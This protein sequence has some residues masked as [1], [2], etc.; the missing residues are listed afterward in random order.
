MDNSDLH[1]HIEANG[2]DAEIL[3]MK[4]RVHSVEAAS[5]ELG[6]PPESFI[7][8]VVFVSE[9]KAILA[10]VKGTDRASSKRIIKALTIESARLATPEEALSL[11]GYAV[12]GTPPISITGV[13]V[14]VDPKVMEMD[15]VVGGGGTDRHLL[16]I[17]PDDIVK[18]NQATVARVRK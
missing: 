2:I 5:N 6:L 11:T 16:R 4:G 14:L 10:I 9:G 17:K 12:G 8:T 7:K 13:H 18:D 3:S 15:K 1:K